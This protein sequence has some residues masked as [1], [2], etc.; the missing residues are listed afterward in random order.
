MKNCR[1][2]RRQPAKEQG[3][4]PCHMYHIP[5]EPPATPAAHR[6]HPGRCREPT[7][8]QSLAG[9]GS[10]GRRDKGSAPPDTTPASQG[11]PRSVGSPPGAPG[12]TEVSRA[13]TAG[14]MGGHSE[15]PRGPPEVSLPRIHLPPGSRSPTHAH[16]SPWHPPA[17]LSWAPEKPHHPERSPG[18][19]IFHPGGFP[20]RPARQPPPSRQDPAPAP[21]Q[22]PR[23]AAAAGT[24][25]RRSH[26]R[27]GTGR[28]APGAAPAAPAEPGLAHLPRRPLLPRTE[29]PPPGAAALPLP[30]PVLPA[31]RR[32]PRLQPPPTRAAAGAGSGKGGRAPPPR[33]RPCPAP[34]PSPAGAPRPLRSLPCPT[35]PRDPHGL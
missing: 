23:A 32:R 14:D 29:L 24:P 33:P 27:A 11:A 10:A 9:R 28:A 4:Q 25:P 12:P 21:A 31:R 7:G 13:V 3:A 35:S 19:P 6:G 2:K 15:R 5:G 20:P 18:P 17:S 22:S 1:G 30:V 26:P 16:A 8:S 34:A